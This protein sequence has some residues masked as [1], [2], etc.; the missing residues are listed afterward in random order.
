[1]K[2]P[3][4]GLGGR[5]KTESIDP[6]TERLSGEDRLLV[7]RLRAGDAAAFAELVENYGAGM[8]NVALFH[9][10]S[11]AV[12][13]EVVQEAW[14]GVLTAL[15]RFEGRSSL[16][17]WLMSILRHT[18]LNRAR[19]ERQTVP[20]S[21]LGDGDSSDEGPAV[22]P[23]RFRGSD[24]PWPGHWVSAPVGWDARPEDWLLS[25]ETIECAENAIAALPA[26]Q[27]AVIELRDIRGWKSIEVCKHLDISEANQRVLLHRARSKVRGALEKHHD[28][29]RA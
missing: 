8:L 21:S 26:N 29:I 17:T 2:D 27:R 1:M 9:V 10:S 23:E 6:P 24:D 20:F 19:K 4:S 12:A 7:D 15:E 22:A 18:A 13:E 5:P 3:G 25:K 16:K 11:R 14:L 28:D